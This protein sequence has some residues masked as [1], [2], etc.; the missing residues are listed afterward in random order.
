MGF[1][2]E[3]SS[4]GELGKRFLI[5]L[6]WALVTTNFIKTAKSPGRGNVF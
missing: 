4:E 6:Q 3:E 1:H 2:P 5:A